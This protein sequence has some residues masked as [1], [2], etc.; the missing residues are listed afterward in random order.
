[1]GDERHAVETVLAAN[2]TLVS[3]QAEE[4]VLAPAESGSV[5]DGTKAFLSLDLLRRQRERDRI[6]RCCAQRES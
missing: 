4:V 5:M 6:A 2:E 3:L 1:M